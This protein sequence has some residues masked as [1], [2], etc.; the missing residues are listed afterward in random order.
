M[1]SGC[2]GTKG[3]SLLDGRSGGLLALNVPRARLASLRL[4]LEGDKGVPEKQG[5]SLQR[6]GVL[7]V[8]CLCHQCLLNRVLLLCFR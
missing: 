4:T 7:N 1:A 5:A 2:Y 6:K 8:P 3:N